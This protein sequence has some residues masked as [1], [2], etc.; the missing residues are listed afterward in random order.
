VHR[1]GLRLVNCNS[2]AFLRLTPSFEITRAKDSYTNVG[3]SK[4]YFREEKKKN[5]KQKAIAFIKKSL[6][7]FT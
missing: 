4:V 3:R 6:N 1:T 5:K 7:V 2:K